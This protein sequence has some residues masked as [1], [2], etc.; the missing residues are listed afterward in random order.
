MRIKI[1]KGVA[2]GVLIDKHLSKIATALGCK[3]LYN[4]NTKTED[5]SCV[6]L[7][8]LCKNSDII[9]VHTPLNDSTRGM[10]NDKMIFFNQS[11][12]EYL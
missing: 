12:K 5:P 8:E 3:V 2:Y 9:S 1:E 11:F 4:K 7:E 10:I 6:S